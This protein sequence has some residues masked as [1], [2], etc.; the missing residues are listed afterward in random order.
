MAKKTE[1]AKNLSLIKK[2]LKSAQLVAVTKYSPAE[3]MLSAYEAHHYDFG[4]NRVQDLVEKAEFFKSRDLNKVRWHFIGHLQTNKVRELFKVPNLYAIHSVDSLRLTE[5]LIKRESELSVP[6]VKIF[7]Q[8]NTS[9][10]EEKSGFET[11]EELKLAMELLLSRASAKLK[12]T[13]LMTMGTIRTREFEA[14]AVKCFR[15]LGVIAHNLETA[16][17]LK[18][19]LKLSMGMSQDYKLALEAG[20]DY[21][22]VGSAIF[23]SS[24]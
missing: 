10:E 13:G 8:V 22:R 5:E 2:E 23:K 16:F 9:R 4:E 7:F 11:A 17:G 12:L 15:D 24:L 18:N 3:E 1:I 14:E 20:S 19:R 6:E 21:I